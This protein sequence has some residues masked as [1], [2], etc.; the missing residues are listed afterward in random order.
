MLTTM[1]TVVGVSVTLETRAHAPG[2]LDRSDSQGL[3]VDDPVV[4]D[5]GARVEQAVAREEHGDD[6]RQHDPASPNLGELHGDST[7]LRSTPERRGRPQPTQGGSG[8]ARRA[9]ASPG[10]RS[11]SRA[12]STATTV[13]A[14]H[15]SPTMRAVIVRTSLSRARKVSLKDPSKNVVGTTNDVTDGGRPWDVSPGYRTT[16]APKVIV[17]GRD[18]VEVEPEHVEPVGRGL[19]RQDRHLAEQ[20]VVGAARGGA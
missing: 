18:R 10:R 15:P 7:C 17:G 13:L 4:M 2:P 8:P 20:D 1:V 3:V 11:R 5:V 14:T 19:T 9:T 12:A 16:G 6:D